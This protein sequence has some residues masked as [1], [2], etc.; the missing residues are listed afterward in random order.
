MG[1]V[2]EAYDREREQPV[3]LKTLQHVSPDAIYRFKR[4]FRSLAEIVHPHLVSLYELF[5]ESDQWFFTMELVGDGVPFLSHLANLTVIGSSVKE[6]SGSAASPTITGSLE[7]LQKSVALSDDQTL[8]S[9]SDDMVQTLAQAKPSSPDNLLLP[10][11]KSRT[12]RIQF[13][14][15]RATE[16]RRTFCQLTEGVRALHAAN[17]L[18]RD[19]K[20]GNVLLRGDGRVVIL[21]FGLILERDTLLS[22]RVRLKRAYSESAYETDTRLAGTIAYMSPEQANGDV[23]TEASDWYAVGIMLFEVLSGR[24][25]FEGTRSEVLQLKQAKKTAPLLEDY[26]AGI[27]ED[28][29]RLCQGLLHCDSALRPAGADVLARLSEDRHVTPAATEPDVGPELFIGRERYTQTLFATFDQMLSGGTSVLHLHA[30]SGLGKTALL[31]HFLTRVV[32]SRKAL[33]FRGRCYE[34]ESVPYKALDSVVDALSVF[35]VRLPQAA[36]AE[37]V[38]PNI[39]ALARVFT[40]LTRSPAV[41]QIAEWEASPANLGELRQ[42]AFAALK[43]LL[44]RIGERFSLIVCI[45]DLQWGDADSAA[46]LIQ[47]LK[48]PRA[49]RLL[50][51]VSYRSEYA[52]TSTCIRSLGTLSSNGISVVRLPVEAL[53]ADET[54]E[55]VRRISGRHQHVLSQQDIHWVLQQSGGNPYFVYELV[56]YLNSGENTAALVHLD[57]ILWQRINRLPD[58]ARELLEVVAVSSQPIKLRYAQQAAKVLAIPPQVVTGLRSQHL[59]RSTGPSLDDEIE[60][61]HDRIRESVLVNLADV[62]LKDHHRNL[63]ASLETAPDIAPEVLAPHYQFSE[64][65]E[66]A[67]Q[68]YEMAAERAVQA[69]AFERAEDFYQ[70]ALSLTSLEEVKVRVAERLIHFYTDLARFRDAYDTGRRALVP[71]GMKLPANFNPAPFVRDLAE[72]WLRFLGRTIAS[73]PE[74]PTSSDPR[75]NSTIRILAAM[76]KAAY[77]IRPELCI[78]ILVKLVNRCLRSGNT[79]DCAVGYM[80]VGTIFIGGILGRHRDGYEFGSACLE[81][82]EKYDNRRQRAE[83]NFVVGYFGTSWVRPARDAE[84][85]WQ[86]AYQTGLETNDLFHTGCACCATTMSQFMRGVPLEEIWTGSEDYVALLQRFSLRESLGAVQA[87]R[88][89]IRNLRGQTDHPE[90]FS[91]HDFDETQFE[92]DL[93]SYGS[94]HFAHYY[95]IMKMQVLYLRGEHQRAIDTLRLSD[96][97]VGHSKGMLHSTEHK[98]YAALILASDCTR[99]TWLKRTQ[100]LI[101]IRGVQRGFQKWSGDCPENFIARERILHGEISRLIKNPQVALSAYDEAA[102]QANRFGQLQIEALAHQLASKLLAN[103]DPATAAMRLAHACDC[104]ELWGATQYAASLSLSPL[105]S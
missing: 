5:L 100:Q 16:I 45:D 7:N 56:R 40:V 72:V 33:V 89:A 34:Q 103:T 29:R 13:D 22:H 68:K 86:I 93:S 11:L 59:L 41:K 97:Y 95:W 14:P 15:T 101:T 85:L 73:I 62:R 30:K 64:Q 4:E 43:E 46:L 91:S 76:G 79:P 74:L 88:Q 18:H 105:P 49:P 3:A 28:L 8:L 1:V 48:G 99:Q 20:P 92:A 19:L 50:L 83:V 71:L 39:S 6:P 32:E 21:D 53:T 66:K 67:A 87:V 23:L 69:L 82:V 10:S 51:L 84:K 24:L 35:L 94:R 60:T 70:R 80:A 78:A 9:S 38:P 44:Y 104:Y 2:Y 37:L 90:H 17:K 47:L 25:P 63:A 58:D 77:Q 57:G 12:P 52:D 27:P 102:E 61:Y 36:V 81:L 75:L 55:L 31:G 54:R 96:E 26:V 42:R 98:F 65:P